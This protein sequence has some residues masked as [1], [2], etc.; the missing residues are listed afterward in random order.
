ME[1]QNRWKAENWE[2]EALMDL[3]VKAGAK[4]FISLAN[5]RDNFDA[6]DSK[7]HPWNSVRVGPKKDIVGI[8]AKDRGELGFDFIRRV[9]TA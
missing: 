9:P 3:Y 2:P 4:Y 1:M 7:D 5:H 8:W 6:Y